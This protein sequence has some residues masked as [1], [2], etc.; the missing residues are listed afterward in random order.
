MVFFWELL[1][2]G[3][4]REWEIIKKAADVVGKQL[5][6]GRCS[7]EDSP[8]LAAR[9]TVRSIPTTLLIKDGKEA[10]R[11]VGLRHEGTL[12]RH[13]TKYLEQEP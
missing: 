13:L 9:L 4:Q 6:I 11:F 12:I 3:C 5:R 10:E 8:E 2:S 1:E 7:V